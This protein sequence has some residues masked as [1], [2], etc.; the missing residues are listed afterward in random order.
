MLF[1]GNSTHTTGDT[2]QHINS[3][4]M[5]FMSQLTAQHNMSVQNAA[6]C[7]SDRF[8]EV[9]TIHQYGV[10]SGNGTFRGSSGALQKFRHLCI[11]AGWIPSGYRG[12]STGKADFPLCHGKTGQGIHH[13]KD[14][15]TLIPE[16]FCDRSCC[17]RCLFTFQC[18]FI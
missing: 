12:L 9:V 10:K 18:R 17:H 15:F 1:C 16:V 7:I 3:R 4:V 6:G 11:N 5:I 8:I 14:I 13:Q 2:C